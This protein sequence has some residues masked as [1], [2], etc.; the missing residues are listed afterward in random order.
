MGALLEVVRMYQNDVVVS[1][2]ACQVLGLIVQLSEDG[3]SYVW[4]LVEND[5]VLSKFIGNIF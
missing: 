3:L 2:L 5:P 4:G 1:G